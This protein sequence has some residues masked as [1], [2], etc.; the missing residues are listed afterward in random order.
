MNE[1]SPNQPWPPAVAIALAVVDLT[2]IE[3]RQVLKTDAQVH[4]FLALVRVLQD[5]NPAPPQN[6][7][8][9]F[10]DRRG[11][12]GLSIHEV[13]LRS[14]PTAAYWYMRSLYGSE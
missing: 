1:F 11:T 10:R 5:Y 2:S 14:G 7:A 12:S 8:R 9:A 3:A 6:A 13:L 4:T